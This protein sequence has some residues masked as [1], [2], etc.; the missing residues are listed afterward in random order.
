VRVL[1]VPLA[2]VS[3]KAIA[4]RQQ[5]KLKSKN[6]REN[7]S[8]PQAGFEPTVPALQLYKMVQEL[9]LSPAVIEILK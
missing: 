3:R 9:D 2:G 8:F 1:C 6:T 4:Y 7:P 5:H